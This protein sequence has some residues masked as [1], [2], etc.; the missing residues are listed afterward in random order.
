[1]RLLGRAGGPGARSHG[2]V[3]LFGEAPDLRRDH[4]VMR[5]HSL[6]CLAGPVVLGLKVAVRICRLVT[7]NLTAAPFMVANRLFVTLHAQL[8]G[9]NDLSVSL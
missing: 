7:V 4:A 9:A 2:R 8:V 3:D 6:I 1:M 5:L